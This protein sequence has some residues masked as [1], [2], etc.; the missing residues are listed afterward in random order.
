M[1]ALHRIH[2]RPA[3]MKMGDLDAL[4]EELSALSRQAVRHGHKLAHAIDNGEVDAVRV[5]RAIDGVRRRVFGKNM[6]VK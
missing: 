5:G 3:V 6:E 4:I 2:E 1:V